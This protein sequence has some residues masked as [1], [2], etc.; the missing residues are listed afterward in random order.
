M[1]PHISGELPVQSALPLTLRC[2]PFIMHAPDHCVEQAMCCGAHRVV[3]DG[4]VMEHADRW[5]PWNSAFVAATSTN[6]NSR[7]LAGG[8][9]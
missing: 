6:P 5:E 2:R 3:V 4:R 9:S 1:L 8:L 7:H